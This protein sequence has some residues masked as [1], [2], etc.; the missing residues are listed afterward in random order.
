M[1]YGLI[2]LFPVQIARV[3][4]LVRSVSPVRLAVGTQPVWALLINGRGFTRILR[5]EP[6]VAP[7]LI[8]PSNWRLPRPESFPSRQAATT[9]AQSMGLM[10]RRTPWPIRESEDASRSEERRVG[11]ECVSTCRSRW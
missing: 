5:N 2:S 9:Y 3:L 4:G 1:Q 10:P 6:L 8:R 11:K 7:G